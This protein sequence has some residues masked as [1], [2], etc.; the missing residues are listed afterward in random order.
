MQII[1]NTSIYN[2]YRIILYN[3]DWY[4]D[5]IPCKNWKYSQFLSLWNIR[6][7]KNLY[8]NFLKFN[9]VIFNTFLTAEKDINNIVI[10]WW[11]YKNVYRMKTSAY[12]Y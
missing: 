11:Y 4:I 10:N 5:I 2:Y 1:Y 8:N 6:K 7:F 9:L 3:I 12:Y